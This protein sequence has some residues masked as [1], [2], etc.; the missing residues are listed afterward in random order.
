MP[1]SL[2]HLRRLIKVYPEW[3][4]RILALVVYEGCAVPEFLLCQTEVP[5]VT[6]QR[7]E[8]EQRE[9]AQRTVDAATDAPDKMPYSVP[10]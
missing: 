8:G 6:N 4:C 5:V 9:R 1:R 2:D 10:Q 7:D 3:L